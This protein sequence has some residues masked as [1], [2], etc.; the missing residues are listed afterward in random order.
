M[1]LARRLPGVPITAFDTDW[2]ARAATR[3]MASTNRCPDVAIAGF[4]APRWLD[5]NLRPGSFVL[6]DCEGYEGELF[7]RASTPA[8]DSATLLIEVHDQSVPGV[9]AAV[10]ERFDRTHTIAIVHSGDRIRPEM[11]LGFLSTDEAAKAVREFREPQ[12]WLFARPRTK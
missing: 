6:A 5:H 1:G 9:G 2:W 11:D 8:L 12:D 7:T 3:E 10:R 4:C